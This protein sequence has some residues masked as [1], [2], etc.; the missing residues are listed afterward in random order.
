MMCSQNKDQTFF[1]ILTFVSPEKVFKHE[2]AAECSDFFP[3]L[4]IKQ[5][6]FF[7]FIIYLVDQANVNSMKQP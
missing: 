5:M 1:P 7:D 4:G 6:F 2:A 3:S